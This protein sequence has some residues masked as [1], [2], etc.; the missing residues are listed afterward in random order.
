MSGQRAVEY[1]SIRPKM[2]RM[3]YPCASRCC[4]RVQPP[5]TQMSWHRVVVSND[6]RVCSIVPFSKKKMMKS[7]LR[8]NKDLIDK[9]IDKSLCNSSERS[10]ASLSEVL[11]HKL[12]VIDFSFIFMIKVLDSII[13][14]KIFLVLDKNMFGIF[15]CI[16]LQCNF[17]KFELRHIIQ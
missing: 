13:F 16:Y 5:E 10:E 2:L 17:V 3:L 15:Y 9:H 8:D 6:E 12:I 1:F 4:N 11:A 7:I 14:P